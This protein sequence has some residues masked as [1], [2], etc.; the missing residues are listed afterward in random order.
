MQK[1]VLYTAGYEGT[2]LDSFVKQLKDND[3]EYEL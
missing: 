2:D 1:T 3:I